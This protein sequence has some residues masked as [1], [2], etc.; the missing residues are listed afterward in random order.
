MATILQVSYE[1]FEKYDVGQGFP[2]GSLEDNPPAK[3][4]DAENAG[5]IPG[6]RRFPGG[7]NGIYSR[8]FVQEISWT[9]E[10][11]KLQSMVLQRVGQS[12]VTEHNT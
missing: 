3:A 9:E 7:E 10:A 4:R 5:L 8:I 6:S 2:G 1:I 12:L 11:G